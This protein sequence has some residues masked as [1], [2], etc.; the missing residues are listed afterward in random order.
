MER[1]RR[2]DEA[3]EVLRTLGFPRQQQNDRSALTLLALLDLKPDE[4]WSKSRAPLIGITPIM[5]FAR[6]HYSKIY[7]PNTRE[8]FRRQ[9]VHQFRDAG[10]IIA[11]P[12]APA[13]AV[14]SPKA[15]YQ[16]EPRALTLLRTHGARGWEKRVKRYLARLGTLASRY[17][18]KRD[19]ARIP[20]TLPDGRTV[21][22]TPGGQNELISRIIE[23]FCPRFAPGSR[24]IYLGDTGDKFSVY[25]EGAFERLG[26]AID[27]HGKM[28]DIVIHR[29]DHDWLLLIE[30]VTSHGPV[31]PKRR[32]ELAALF[33]RSTAGLVYVTAFLTRR[34]MLK[35]LADISWE[36]EVWIAESPEHMIHF[37][38]ERFLG[39]YEQ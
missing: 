30:A 5:D 22:L 35:Y 32:A 19:M 4:P 25:D 9:T 36:S 27:S 18:Q 38:G 26:I 15:V 34:A 20:V 37:D 24:L 13:R 14:N 29:T 2:L 31:N 8:T 6:D 3:R 17:A 16:I 11:N 10:I 23:E 28:P 21:K 33:G 1:K 39:P 7:K 12:D